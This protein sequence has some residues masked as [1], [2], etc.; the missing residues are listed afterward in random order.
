VMWLSCNTYARYS[1]ILGAYRTNGAYVRPYRFVQSLLESRLFISQRWFSGVTVHQRRQSCTKNTDNESTIY[2]ALD[3]QLAQ[4]D[5]FEWY[6]FKVG[7][8]NA[9]VQENVHLKF[10]DDVLGVL[11][12]N[13]PS[14]FETTFKEWLCQ[15]C[16]PGDSVDEVE[17]KVGPHP[18][19]AF[20]RWKFKQ[21]ETSL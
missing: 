8:H 21:I 11:V 14:F 7:S 6:R 19:E 18:V 16:N 2:R 12:L 3:K 5:G 17:I 1:S 4:R 15:Q 20:F 9:I 13:T 10:E